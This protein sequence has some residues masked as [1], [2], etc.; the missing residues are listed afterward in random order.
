MPSPNAPDSSPAAGPVVVLPPPGVRPP[1][2]TS[3]S[4]LRA[5][6]GRRHV[7][8]AADP[9]QARPIAA[10]MSAAERGSRGVP[11]VTLT[12][13]E[14][15]RLPAIETLLTAKTDVDPVAAVT[16]APPSGR[17]APKLARP[18]PGNGI[19]RPLS[20]KMPEAI[21]EAMVEMWTEVLCADYLARHPEHLHPTW[22]MPQHCRS[23]EQRCHEHAARLTVA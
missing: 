3:L 6:A 18:Q 19:S 22:R 16:P 2:V 14:S 11:R 5:A 9:P 23:A 17:T 8:R 10:T 20:A 1:N 13:D 7:S 4:A 12:C 21:F 15:L